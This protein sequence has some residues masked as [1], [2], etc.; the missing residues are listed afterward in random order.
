MVSFPMMDVDNERQ[1]CTALDTAVAN[2]HGRGKG[3]NME[4]R[5]RVALRYV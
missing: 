2:A 1:E 4:R 5:V 3:V